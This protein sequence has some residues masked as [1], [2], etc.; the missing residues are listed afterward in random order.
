MD[1]FWQKVTLTAR[2][3]DGALE[4]S[5]LLTDNDN[6]APTTTVDGAT[7]NANALPFAQK[8]AI[9]NALR[10]A[11]APLGCTEQWWPDHATSIVDDAEAAGEV[12]MAAALRARVTASFVERAKGADYISL[13]SQRLDDLEAVLAAYDPALVTSVSVYDS[14]LRT[15]PRSLARFANLTRLSL[16]EPID[17][18]GLRGL[19][20]P[21]LEM[22]NLCDTRVDELRREDVAGFPELAQLYLCRCPLTALDPDIIEVCPKL[23]RVVVTE[24]PLDRDAA[25]MAVLRERWPGVVWE[26]EP[27]TW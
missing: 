3:P 24:T 6:P 12:A 8:L 5:L 19:A 16:S 17:S 26:P 14:E 10:D 4:L 22:L 18:A 27:S 23:A 11:L 20:L 13:W 2:R 15:V 1:F 21:K 9:W 25:K 7:M